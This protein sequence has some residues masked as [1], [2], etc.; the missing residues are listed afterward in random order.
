[1]SESDGMDDVVDSGLRQ[2]LM[3][4][5]RIAETLARKR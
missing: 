2:S 4:A 5:S 1:M 3:V